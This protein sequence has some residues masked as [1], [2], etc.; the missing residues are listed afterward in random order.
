MVLK[1]FHYLSQNS[2]YIIIG[3]DRRVQITIWNLKIRG[4]IFSQSHLQKKYIKFHLFSLLF[5]FTYIPFVIQS[6]II[7]II[8]TMCYRGEAIGLYIYRNLFNMITLPDYS[9]S[10]LL[11]FDNN[12]LKMARKPGKKRKESP[13]GFTGEGKRWKGNKRRVKRR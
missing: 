1:K 9:V 10:V 12:K 11:L 13:V 7:M 5:H 2:S 8:V 4:D 3:L 6:P